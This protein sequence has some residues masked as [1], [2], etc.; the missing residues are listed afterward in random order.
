VV[1]P[2]WDPS[3]LLVRCGKVLIGAVGG[4]ALAV[5]IERVRLPIGLRVATEAGVALVLIDVVSEVN[6]VV[7]RVLLDRVGIGIEVALS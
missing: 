1:V 5:V 2:D 3:E 6:N 4:N 7:D